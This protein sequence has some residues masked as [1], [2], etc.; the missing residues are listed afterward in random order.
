MSKWYHPSSLF[1]KFFEG[2]VI[3]KGIDGAL[4]VLGGIFV[5]FLTPQVVHD[6]LAWVT[7]KE[8]TEDP[9]DTLANFILHLGDHFNVGN[10]WFAAIYLLIHG[11]IKLV[12]V[13]GL[14]RNQRWAYPF[15]LIT[16]GLLLL[17]Q[18]VS[19][20]VHPSIGMTLLSIFDVVILWL[21]WREYRKIKTAPHGL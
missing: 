11:G 6:F 16:L 20:A 7:Q 14:L 13:Y 18:L 2:G 1:D 9:H 10:K 4:E 19:I 15:S 17:Y 8:I 21:I 5:I 3:L 12:A